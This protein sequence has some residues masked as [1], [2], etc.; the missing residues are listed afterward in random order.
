MAVWRD[1][2]DGPARFR[3]H[4]EPPIGSLR[5]AGERV[6]ITQE[7]VESLLHH[8]DLLAQLLRMGYARDPQEQEM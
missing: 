8:V 2:A 1:D 3:T 6:H 5:P 7:V 4:G